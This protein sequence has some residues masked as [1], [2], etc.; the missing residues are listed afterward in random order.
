MAPVIRNGKLLQKLF[1][2]M[3]LLLNL[4]VCVGFFSPFCSQVVF[5]L[6]DLTLL[7]LNI[8]SGCSLQT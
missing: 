1:G 4:A 5:L 8:F 3:F 7:F 6:Y 2:F